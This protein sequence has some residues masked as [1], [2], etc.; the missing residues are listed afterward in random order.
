MKEKVKI[1]MNNKALKKKN[2]Y[3]I[4]DRIEFIF[5]GAIRN[6]CSGS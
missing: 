2:S 5:Y 4:V 1:F 6:F 3:C